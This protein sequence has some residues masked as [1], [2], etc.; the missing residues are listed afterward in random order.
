MNTPIKQGDF[1]I[2]SQ[3]LPALQCFQCITLRKYYHKYVFH[4]SVHQSPICAFL[5][6][7]VSNTDIE[8]FPFLGECGNRAKRYQ[9]FNQ[10]I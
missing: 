1:I 10:L 5:C 8:S 4:V 9:E 2:P 3:S 6:Y 7:Q